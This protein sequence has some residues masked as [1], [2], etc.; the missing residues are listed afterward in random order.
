MYASGMF[1]CK[2][3]GYE[4][5][6]TRHNIAVRKLSD[7]TANHPKYFENNVHLVEANIFETDFYEHRP[8]VF[9]LNGGLFSER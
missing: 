1:K 3:V 8:N 7:I 4:Y 5:S 6:R 2:S 9:L